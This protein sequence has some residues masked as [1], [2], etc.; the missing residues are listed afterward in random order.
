MSDTP[1]MAIKS[2]TG[3]ARADGAAGSSSWHW[4]VRSVNARGLDIRLRVPPGL[5][6]LEPRIREALAKRITRG[7]LA[8]NLNVKRVQGQAPQIRL[9]EAALQQVLTA[10]DRVKAT[11]GIGLH[12]PEALLAIKGVL[13]LVEPE[14]S[15][16]EAAART[17]AR[18]ASL[19]AAIEGMV[20]PRADEGRRL[21]AIVLEQLATIE[22][23]VAA[24]E[25]LPARSAEA[26]RLR[27]KEQIGRLLDAGAALDEDRLYQEA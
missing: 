9:N 18:L 19:E 23:L 24:V 10:L 11:V 6:G 17:E 7:S 13:E 4:E 15:E 14:E 2:M 25:R 3:F 20:R 27:L 8:V 5:E 16:A 26:V 22:R 12:N 1:R 21:R